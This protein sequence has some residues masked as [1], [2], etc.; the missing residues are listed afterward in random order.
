MV[1][2]L[3]PDHPLQQVNPELKKQLERA[4]ENLLVLH[5]A[6]AGELC[7]RV[8]QDLRITCPIPDVLFSQPV[9]TLAD[10]GFSGLLVLFADL[11]RA[12][13]FPEQTVPL[14]SINLAE[15]LQ[16][17]SAF[18]EPDLVLQTV[19]AKVTEVVAGFPKTASD[20]ERGRNPGDVLDPYILAACQFLLVG[21]DFQLAIESTVTH[22]ALMIIEGLLGHLHEDT[23]GM[24]RGNVRAPEP[25]G[26][27]QETLDPLINPFPGADVV[28]PPWSE[29]RPVRFHQIKSKSGSAK[30]GDGKRLGE[31]LQRL[32][33]RY[34]G[35]IYYH[36]LIGN[37][38][39]GHRSRAAVEKAA[40]RAVTLIGA[41]SFQELTSSPNGAE[42]LLRVYQTA[43]RS[44][45]GTS[46]YRLSEM[47]NG[48]VATFQQRA[49]QLGEGYLETILR[50]VT[51]GP[52]E[53]QDSRLYKS[54]S[55]RQDQ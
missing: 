9:A 2:Y 14:H 6:S 12:A 11:L 21:G 16:L 42:L 22:K 34:G 49:A 39:R 54:R 5:F 33:N 23:I 50:D 24:M 32:Q 35:D 51:T 55:T 19:Q 3:P 1:K 43:F 38:L 37:T 48:I 17:V 28:Q 4:Q 29:N 45:A 8:F 40:P 7:S 30:G 27:D 46:G 52:I 47:V 31:Q 13:E 25:R 15:R 36:A 26:V 41:A 20:I 44:V 10:Q 53:N 18:E